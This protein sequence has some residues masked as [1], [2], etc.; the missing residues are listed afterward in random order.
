MYLPVITVKGTYMIDWVGRREN[1][2]FGEIEF[3]QIEMRQ[4]YKD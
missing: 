1:E 3:A 2:S 4:L